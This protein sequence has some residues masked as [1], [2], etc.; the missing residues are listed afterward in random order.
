MPTAITKELMSEYYQRVYPVEL[1]TRW[2]KYGEEGAF[3]GRREFCFT[4]VGDIFT[5]FRSYNTE[6][7]LKAD[8]IKN[9]PEKIDIGAVYATAPDK[10]NTV[11]LVTTQ[12]ELVFDIDMSDYDELR[13]CCKGK[14]VC[15][16]CWLWMSTAAHILRD[17]MVTDFGFDVIVPVFSGRRG[18]HLWVLDE[19]ARLLT[20]EE[21]SAVVGYCTVVG[22]KGSINIVGSLRAQKL[23]PSLIRVHDSIIAPRFRQLFL[24]PSRTLPDG[25]AVANLNCIFENP[26]AAKV[27]YD[28]ALNLEGQLA[29][30][31]KRVLG[32]QLVVNDGEVFSK[33][34]WDM[35][36]KRVAPQVHVALHFAAMYPRLDEK[37][38]TRRDHLLKLPFCIHP[39]TG[40]LCV[41]LEWS[42]LDDFDPQAHPPSVDDLL[43]ELGAVPPQW[44]APML[45]ALETLEQRRTVKAEAVKAERD[46]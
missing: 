41:P 30:S 16:S 18:I 33:A 25:S 29:A 39:G 4:L 31:T 34:A 22:E 42:K 35:V 27:I 11:T 23:H 37:V 19:A 38:S 15:A 40:R 32:D 21:R 1:V 2:L 43:H 3:L 12:R 26:A 13:S 5:R 36:D 17:L 7:L 20:D 14:Q 24:E 28:L 46:E 45:R 9:G 6:A 10:K 44:S 8:L